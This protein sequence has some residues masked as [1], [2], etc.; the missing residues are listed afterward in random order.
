[1]RS[2]VLLCSYRR[3]VELWPVSLETIIVIAIPKRILLE[4][5]LVLFVRSVKCFQVDNLRDHLSP[6]VLDFS[7]VNQS[8]QL[9]LYILGNLLLVLIGTENDGGILRSHVVPLSIHCCWVVKLEKEPDQGFVNLWVAKFDEQNFDMTRS[10]RANL[11][12]GWVFHGIRVRRHETNS[13]LCNGP[14]EF[15]LK[16]LHDEL[17]SSPVTTGSKGEGRC[18]HGTTT[19]RQFF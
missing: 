1:M 6:C 19:F 15:F 3:L 12:V 17:F 11:P 8:L 18:N 13:G 2:L 9:V 16:I 14:R 4:I 7:S 10:A 5:R